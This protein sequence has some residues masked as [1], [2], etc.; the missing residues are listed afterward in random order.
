[1]SGGDS[2]GLVGSHGHGNMTC[3]LGFVDGKRK[4][5]AIHGRIDV[6]GWGKTYALRV[7]EEAVIAQMVVCIVNAN[8]QKNSTEQLLR[9]GL[10][11]GTS[12]VDFLNN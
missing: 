8:V 3:A 4:L 9:I 11:V 7:D 1:M 2:V 10:G 6:I 5:I 12:G